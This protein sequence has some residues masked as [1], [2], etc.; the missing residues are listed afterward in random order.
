MTTPAVAS[1]IAA[2]S[3]GAGRLAMLAGFAALGALAT[4]IM[5]PA[6]PAM[7]RD[8]SVGQPALAWTLSAFFVT[9]A[10]GQLVVGPVTDAIGRSRPVFIGLALFVL[11]S[12]IGAI[13]ATLTAVVV[14]RVIQALGACTTAVLARAIAR[15]LY[16]GPALTRALALIMIAMAAAPGFSP[17]LGTVVTLAFGWRATFAIVLVAAVVLA[18]AYRMSA[19]ETLPPERHT[20]L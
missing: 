11:G 3:I 20:A 1:G 2:S 6:F 10:F 18:L 17:A 9:F 7:A 14:G 13:A 4:N 15:D 5:L 8:L 12:A 19:G 16:H